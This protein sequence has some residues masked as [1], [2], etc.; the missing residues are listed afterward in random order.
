MI[1]SKASEPQM[2]VRM[3]G[4]GENDS[5]DYTQAPRADFIEDSS[6]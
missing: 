6:R 2:S 1:E 4:V 3:T 5:G